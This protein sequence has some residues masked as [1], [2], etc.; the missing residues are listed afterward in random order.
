MINGRISAKSFRRY[1]LWPAIWPRLRPD[2]ILAISENDARR[3]AKLFGMPAVTVMPNIKFDRLQPIQ[4][5]AAT[6]NP[7]KKL[8]HSNTPFVVL[9]SVRQ[10]EEA[11]VGKII[12][13]I[14]KR[15]PA[16]VIGLVPRHQ[17]RIEY[18]Q[19]T[20]KRM[21]IPWRLRSETTRP[22]TPA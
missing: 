16:T 5:D 18:W 13:H 8:L 4:S 2:Q 1:R 22:I 3:F 12:G 14:R 21:A 9:A 19:T 20:L 15:Y 11:A 7:I 6:E 10:E 17:H